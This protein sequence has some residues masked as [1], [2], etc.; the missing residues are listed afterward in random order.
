MQVRS[1]H[2]NHGDQQKR[3]DSEREII[4]L[5]DLRKIDE[6]KQACADVLVANQEEPGHIQWGN[7][8]R[9]FFAEIRAAD[10]Q[11]RT[12][13]EFQRKIWDDNPVT[14]TRQG[15]VSVDAAIADPEFRRWLAERSLE[16]LP[17]APKARTEALDTLFNELRNRLRPYTNRQ[18]RLKIY[19]VLVGFFPSDFTTVTDESSLLQ[20][21]QKMFGDRGTAGPTLHSN[22]LR[23]LGEVI[24]PADDDLNAIVDRIRLPWLLFR[25]YVA[26][27][28]DDIS[29]KGVPQSERLAPLPATRRRKSLTGVT[30]G[31]PTLLNILEFCRNGA[32]REDL[33]DYIRNVVPGLKDRS[34]D[35][36]IY[37]IKGELNCL[38]SDGDQ[39]VLTDRGRELLESEDPGK[40]MDWLL[41]SILGVDHVLVILRIEE[42]YS[43]AEMARRIQMVNPGWKS[44][45]VPRYIIRVLLE[46]GML[47]RDDRN[48]LS[49]SD[50]GADWAKRIHWEPESL[51]PEKFPDPAAVREVTPEDET[52]QVELP[53]FSE[54][55]EDVSRQGQFAESLIRKLDN[56]IW[57]SNR[58]HFAILT[59]LSGAG[60]TLLA[61][62]YGEAIAGRANSHAG[63]MCT[64]PVQ[65][66]WYDPSA[67][68]GYVNPLQGDSYIRTPFL[69]FLLAA[70][71]SPELPFTVVLDD[72]NLSRPEQYLAP[73]LSAMETGD[74]VNLHREGE[75]FDGVPADVRFPNN[76]VIIGTVNMDETT[77]GISDKV[78]DRAFTIEFWDVDLAKYPHWGKRNLE[79][80]HEA[81]ARKL[82][83]DLMKSLRPARLH[84]GWRVVDDVLDYVERVAV[85]G[86]VSDPANVL[87]DV[88]YAKVLPKLRG[89]DSQRFRQAL[90]NCASVLAE[91]GLNECQNRVRELKDD[92]ESTG[93]A[94]F[95]R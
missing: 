33:K 1:R 72:M 94:R 27:S 24:G 57:A 80:R 9:Q 45:V 6:L 26:P 74:V 40:L 49:L 91:H 61:R 65:P 28:G 12:G 36:A 4:T 3:A 30:G 71:A 38:K 21:H 63:Q 39:L 13:E 15:N 78:L 67:L 89:D 42:S 82:L 29:S 70:A 17:D 2:R 43:M 93:S 35:T 76:L 66:G 25:R 51:T 55:C 52:R 77:H 23:R 31:F 62:A 46:F 34:I 11:T 54:I 37:A 88:V 58:R 68:L 16:Q 87:D 69:E 60:K 75:M 8:L 18:P 44:E 10:L 83:E 14:K 95:W 53:T 5:T 79:P 32:T 48:V 86:G 47:D 73:I 92:L 90:D 41:T 84:F 85:D 19:R 56:G 64:I 22:I 20:L 7:D 59:G 50:A 81:K